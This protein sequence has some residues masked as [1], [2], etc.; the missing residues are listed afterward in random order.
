MK[1]LVVS[2]IV[3]L[4]AM[5]MPVVVYF[6]LDSLIEPHRVYRVGRFKPTAHGLEVL[7]L[8][9][10]W[11]VLAF[12]GAP[13]LALAAGLGWLGG[14]TR[15]DYGNYWRDKRE[16][17]TTDR[18]RE[19]DRLTREAE[20]AR[21]IDQAIVSD[22]K[23]DNMHLSRQA[24][25]DKGQRISAVGELK[26]RRKREEKLRQQLAAANREIERLRRALPPESEAQ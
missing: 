3:L 6:G 1:K 4:V 13:L 10:A 18:M 21:Q 5:T 25:K 17:E 26:R 2:I 22:V 9:A 11:P 7:A 16:K 20:R 15:E 14:K 8:W 23:R 19:A 12:Y 24:G